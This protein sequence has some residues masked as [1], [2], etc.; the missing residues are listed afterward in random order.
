MPDWKQV[1]EDVFYGN[2]GVVLGDGEAIRFLKQRAGESARRRARLCCHAGPD[3]LL[4]DMLIVMQGGAY[5]RPHKHLKK[6]ESFLVIEGTGHLCTF[7]DDGTP[8]SF[9]DFQAP[10]AGGKFFYHMPANIYHTQ[11]ITSDWLVYHESASGPF[12]PE[13]SV[14]APWAPAENDAAADG[15]LQQLLQAATASNA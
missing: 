15:Y 6:S 11:L 2:G 5:I 7:E 13:E 3:A 10:A 14:Q 1:S 12:I 8:R 4:H 9:H